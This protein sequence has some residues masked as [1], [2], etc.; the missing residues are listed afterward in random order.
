MNDELR[1]WD[2]GSKSPALQ[3]HSQAAWHI[4]QLSTSSVPSGQLPLKGKPWCVAMQKP[5]P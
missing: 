5:S 2:G 1:V 4:M 3:L